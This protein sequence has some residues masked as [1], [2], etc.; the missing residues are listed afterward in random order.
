[1]VFQCLVPY[2]LGFQSL[3]GVSSANTVWFVG[4]RNPAELQFDPS[5][6]GLDYFIGVSELPA[7]YSD[8]KPLGR[9][10]VGMVHT[11]SS[12]WFVDQNEGVSLFEL[13]TE[14]NLQPQIK[15]YSTLQLG[16]QVTD[17]VLWEENIVVCSATDSLQSFV[18]ENSDWSALPEISFRNAHV[19]VIG[20]ALV[21]FAPHESGATEWRIVDEK[22]KRYSEH[23]FSGEL[24][25]VR[26]WQEMPIL[27]TQEREQ[28]TVLGIQRGNIVVFSEFQIPK[29]R[30]GI[31]PV[32]SGM[33]VVSVQRNG[34]IQGLEIALP[35]GRATQL[36]DMEQKE[37]AGVSMF[38]SYPFFIPMVVILVAFLI[39]SRKKSAV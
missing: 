15:R 16:E 27:V 14:E 10:P 28:A 33:R 35:T 20:G 12:L 21:A 6:K 22:W 18:Y 38:D 25:D 34:T 23:L 17:V 5:S 24:T 9:R 3:V 8:V 11:D 2:L 37:H 36:K 29:G 13:K 1:M 30:W 4:D 31:F 26:Q 19:C 7:F 39:L 32:D